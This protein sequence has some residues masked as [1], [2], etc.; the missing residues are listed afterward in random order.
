MTNDNEDGITPE[1]KRA[2][3]EA[4]SHRIGEPPPYAERMRMLKM[5]ANGLSVEAACQQALGTFVDYTEPVIRPDDS[6]IDM[7]IKINKPCEFI[8]FNFDK[9]I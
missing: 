6:A 3:E 9:P 7:S 8:E 5:V 2:L 1:I 4:L